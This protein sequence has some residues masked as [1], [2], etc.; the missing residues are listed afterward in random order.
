MYVI[1]SKG[2]WFGIIY[3]ILWKNHCFCNYIMF[4]RKKLQTT[5]TY[6][7]ESNPKCSKRGVS[8]ATDDPCKIKRDDTQ[9]NYP[10]RREAESPL[11]DCKQSNDYTDTWIE[12][13][14]HFLSIQPVNSMYRVLSY[15]II[16]WNSVHTPLTTQGGHNFNDKTW[17]MLKFTIKFWY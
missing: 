2:P 16:V 14:W 3:L 8:K 12:Y 9:N 6:D 4:S 11:G 1:C 17:P 13:W 10:S 7:V 5:T 15:K